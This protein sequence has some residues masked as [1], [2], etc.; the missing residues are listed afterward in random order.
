M[1]TAETVAALRPAVVADLTDARDA[2]HVGTLCR[3][4]A[5]IAASLAKFRTLCDT[6]H[7]LGLSLAHFGA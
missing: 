5:M 3:D 1:N 7:G 6:L 4:E 2:F